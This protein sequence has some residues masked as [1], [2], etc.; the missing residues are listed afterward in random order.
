MP[1]SNPVDVK[2]IYGTAHSVQQLFT[3]RK[4]G[5]DYYQR[6]YAWTRDNVKELIYD[7]SMR[8]LE[9]YKPNHDRIDV[10]RYRPYFLGPVVTSED[11][12][13]RY[14]V[15]GQQRL[16]TLTLL[17]I[18]LNHMA[19]KVDGVANLATLAFSEKFG[20]K[21]FN[22]NIPEREEVMQAILDGSA[23]DP[24]DQSKSV[25]NIWERYQDI[26]I[27]YPD[28]LKNSTLPYFCDWLLERVVLV[29]IDTTDKDM[30]LEVFETMNDR[31]L[32]L[33]NTD[34]LKA[35]LLAGMVEQKTIEDANMLWRVQITAL[36]D[37]DKNAGSDFLKHW[38]RGKYAN[39]IRKRKKDAIDED[40]ELIGRAFHKWVRDNR[41]AIGLGS[42]I[43]YA[44]FVNH[45]FKCM[46][47]RYIHLLKVSR[48][49]TPGWEHVYYNTVIGL[50][51]QYLPIMAAVTPDDDQDTFR[52]K[53]RMIA[54]FLDVFVARRIVNFN[55]FGY[56]TIVYTIFN[57]ARDIRDRDLDTLREVLADRIANLDNSFDGVVKFGRTQRNTPHIRYL[58]ARM[59]AWIENE[60]GNGVGFSEYV[61]RSRKD[62]FEVEHIW[63]NKFERH[64]D[65]FT[66]PHDFEVQ[67]ERFGGLL[68][69]PKSFNAA[70]GDKTYEEKLDHYFGQN[71]LA[72]SLHPHAYENNPSFRRFKEKTELPFRCHHEFKKSDFEER[73]QLYKLICEQVWSPERLGLGGGSP[74]AKKSKESRKARYDIDLSDLLNTG[75]LISGE[76]LRGARSG[77]EYRAE[78]T[79]NGKIR[80]GNN[81][82]FNTLS[83]AAAKLTGQPSN[84][85][86]FWQVDRDGE[87]RELADIRQKYLDM[88]TAS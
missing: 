56:S 44:S 68:L 78:V 57:L 66:H 71:M 7:L 30:A 59:T 16:T 10:A 38:L 67:R 87:W 79:S 43:D 76:R 13:I 27:L 40:F 80:V 58:L 77:K 51:L 37:L 39:E 26:V 4:Y 25:R 62:P 48:S 50:T 3:N 54:A 85:W 42:A 34:M 31:G 72:A 73:Q 18:H 52:E 23:F 81:D 45:D 22:I 83:G 15:D 21:T 86:T 49:L 2:H 55:N 32:R 46:S 65:K 36:T 63:A 19:E 35:F 12:G 60:C 47:N 75:L 33:S 74:S 1:H 84:G 11:G 64:K 9:D 41:K 29:E 20:E 88:S 70:F 5:L 17:L 14:L 69:L 28:E 82:V 53:T 6:E 24:S 8:F 61:D